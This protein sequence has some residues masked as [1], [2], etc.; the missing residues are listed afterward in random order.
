MSLELRFHDE[1]VAEIRSAAAWYENKQPGLGAEFLEALEGRFR[2]LSV[3]PARAGRF[4]GADPSSPIR[5]ATLSRFPYVIVFVAVDESL[6]V[7]AVMHARRRPGYWLK[8]V[9]P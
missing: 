8:R 3:A 7:I 9:T 4:P 6:R 2:Q 1:A 5:R